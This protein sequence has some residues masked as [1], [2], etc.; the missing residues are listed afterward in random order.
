M[1]KAFTLIELLVVISIIALLIA[2]LLPALS[3]A[4][5]SARRTQCLAQ[6]K[7]MATS[8]IAFATDD[9]KG[10]LIPARNQQIGS[11]PGTE[12]FV[13][14]ALN[15]QTFPLEFSPG[16]KEFEDYGFPASL[17]GDPGR[18]GFHVI[19]TTNTVTHGFQYFGGINRWTWMPG[20]PTVIYKG[21]LSPI[22]LE[23]MTSEQTFVAD[24]TLKTNPALTWPQVEAV[25]TTGGFAGTPAHGLSGEYPKGGNHIYGDSSG[26]WVEFSKFKQLHTWSPQRQAWYYQKY[27]GKYVPPA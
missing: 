26:E 16:A 20:S 11:S 5:D 24:L 9:S 22:T 27:L 4:R 1:R 10:R 3:N 21:G 15:F 19:L 17:M 12:Q 13:Q 6:Q 8:S 7:Q 14:T 25:N 2:I 23:D 18:D